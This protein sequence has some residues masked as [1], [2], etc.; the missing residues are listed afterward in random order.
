MTEAAVTHMIFVRVNVEIR[1]E[2]KCQDGHALRH[3][4]VKQQHEAVGM[5]L[6]EHSMPAGA[7]NVRVILT[8]VAPKAI[9][10]NALVSAFQRVAEAVHRWV[11]IDVVCQW[12][13]NQRPLKGER[14]AELTITWDE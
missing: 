2:A 10:V 12:T 11:G 6:A 1:S 4:R 14:F 9:H 13:H 3:H 8:R 7:K 5:A